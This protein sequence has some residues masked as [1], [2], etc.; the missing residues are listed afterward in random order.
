LHAE[1]LIRVER[2]LGYRYEVKDGSTEH[3]QW[4]CPRCRRA[5]LV[6]AQ[7]RLWQD[8]IGG[9][10]IR[11]DAPPSLPQPSFGNSQIDFGPLGEEDARN[12]HA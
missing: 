7:G 10:A 4:I 12:F 8:E 2:A 6:L 5:M 11:I 1:D 9:E 3:Y